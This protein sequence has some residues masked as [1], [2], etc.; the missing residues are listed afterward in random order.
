[1][2][3]VAAVQPIQTREQLLELEEQEILHPQ[4][5]AK[6]ITAALQQQAQITAA[7]AAVARGLSGQPG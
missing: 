1:V 4:V 3:L 2:V 5:Q 6:A 7:V